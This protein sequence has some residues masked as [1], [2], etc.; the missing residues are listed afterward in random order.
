VELVHVIP[1]GDVN[2][3]YDREHSFVM[4]TGTRMMPLSFHDSSFE[5]QFPHD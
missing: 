2:A 3:F 4:L 1:L 5:R